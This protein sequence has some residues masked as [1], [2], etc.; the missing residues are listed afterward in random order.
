VGGIS[1]SAFRKTLPFEG[2]FQHHATPS[3]IDAIHS[4]IV[5]LASRCIARRGIGD[6]FPHIGDATERLGAEFC[7]EFTSILYCKS[8]STHKKLTIADA[9]A[10]KWSETTGKY[11]GCPFWSAGAKTVFD[12]MFTESRGV[13]LEDAW[14]TADRLSKSTR[15]R[16]QQ[17]THEHV[18][19][20]QFFIQILRGLRPED[21]DDT[22]RLWSL[23]SRLAVGCVILESEH[24][25]N[26]SANEENPWR[27]YKGTTLVANA[28]WPEEHR[29]LITE[30][31]LRVAT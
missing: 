3:Q 21:V 23:F 16:D 19:P 30:A 29:R 28:A 27:R 31:R 2:I 17:L 6:K 13:S 11:V 15:P 20:K 1:R 5:D 14:Q 4:R 26:S 24:P 22:V 12:R 10:W 25:P 9:L 7:R 8:F 18:Y